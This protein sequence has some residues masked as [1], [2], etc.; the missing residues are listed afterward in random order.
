ML[1]IQSCSLFEYDAIDLPDETLSGKIV[2]QDG[3]PI[4]VEFGGGA[5][6]VLMDYSTHENPEPQYLT[7]KS[8]GTF[9]N[10]KIFKG[11]YT[12]IAQGPFVPTDS[13]TIE[14]CYVSGKKEINYSVEPYLKLEWIGEPTINSEGS[15]TVK[16]K[17]DRGTDN[18]DYH[19]DL[20]DVRL[21]ISTTK[22]VGNS[23]KLNLQSPTVSGDAA[24]AMVGKENTLTTSVVAADPLDEG[25]PYYLR[26]GA[27]LNYTGEWGSNSYCYTPAV[28]VVFKT[29]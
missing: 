2:D 26:V 15:I 17:L 21:F 20:Q 19:N 22:Y 10:T 23:D 3:E 29:E 11:T 18:V 6:I 7:V 12:A 5:R 16:F 8:D 25:R 4:Q 28:R 14:D 24:T 1:M 13:N 9:I 27:R